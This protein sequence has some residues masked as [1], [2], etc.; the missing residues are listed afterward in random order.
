MSIVRGGKRMT[1]TIPI[2]LYE[3]NQFDVILEV[4]P[5]SA[6]DQDE[7][8]TIQHAGW[9]MKHAQKGRGN[10]Q[11]RWFVLTKK[12]LSY[13]DE[14]EVIYKKRWIMENAKIS[15]SERE[16]GIVIKSYTEDD[17]VEE[18]EVNCMTEENMALSLIHI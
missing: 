5:T 15:E 6:A 11:R 16:F 13:S 3:G 7:D 12:W 18:L 2:G 10:P 17:T 1:L 4:K 9:L 8:N 14:P